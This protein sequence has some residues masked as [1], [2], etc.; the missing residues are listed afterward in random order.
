MARLLLVGLLFFVVVGGLAVYQVRA[1]M[2]AARLGT[3]VTY[4]L[5]GQGHA[6][7]EIVEKTYFVDEETQRN[8]DG[9]V[10][11]MGR[12]DVERFGK[13]IESSIKSLAERTGRVGMAVSDFEARFDRR[14]EYGARVYRFRWMRFAEERDGAW[15]VDFRAADAVKLTRDSSLSIVLPPGAVVATADPRPTAREGGRL[16]WIGAGEMPWPYVEY[17]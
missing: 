3:D 16:V 1:R 4:T 12:P 15:V 11:K 2:T 9:L 6:L 7:V 14:A 5:D 10:A 8:F 17:R 13:G